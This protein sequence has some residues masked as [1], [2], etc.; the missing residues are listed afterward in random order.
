[1]IASNMG[2]VG[3]AINNMSMINARRE[4]DTWQ[5]EKFEMENNQKTQ[6]MNLVLPPK[7]YKELKGELEN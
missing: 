7:K 3:E 1:M 2:K 4:I 6:K 5:S